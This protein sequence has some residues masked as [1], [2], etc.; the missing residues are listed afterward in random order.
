MTE[1]LKDKP[2]VKY[3]PDPMDFIEE[4]R[5]A[6]VYAVNHPVWGENVVYTSPVI[7]KGAFGQFET[8]NTIYVPE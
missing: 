6:S 7:V 2:V 3:R 4:G 8:R 1:Q 5:S